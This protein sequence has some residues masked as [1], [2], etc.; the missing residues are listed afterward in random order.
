M[1][2]LG[3]T[4]L[5][6]KAYHALEKAGVPVSALL[7]R[8]QHA[9]WGAMSQED[10]DLNDLALRQGGRLLSAYT[11]RTGEEI[12]VITEGDHSATTVLLPSEY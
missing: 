9:D 6:T 4:S 12:W 5:T 1:F 11:L 8:H 3:K 2:A 10:W 7:E